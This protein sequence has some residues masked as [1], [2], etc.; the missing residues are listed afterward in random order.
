MSD[1]TAPPS[2]SRLYLATR[3]VRDKSTE[4][5]QACTRRVRYTPIA[6]VSLR[7][8]EPPLRAMCGRLR[9]GKDF[10]HECSI[11]RCGHVFGLRMRF[12]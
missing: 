1:V 3:K 9:V 5:F 11:G 10:L 2:R 6:D 7:R 4:S 12:T 8:S